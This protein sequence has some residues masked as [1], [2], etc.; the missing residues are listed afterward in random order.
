[1]REQYLQKLFEDKQIRNEINLGHLHSDED[2]VDNKKK[3]TLTETFVWQDTLKRKPKSDIFQQQDQMNHS[4]KQTG[5]AKKELQGPAA[6]PL[7]LDTVL[8]KEK[9]LLLFG[10]AG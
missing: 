9:Q 3:W 6:T 5:K 2:M 10:D 1:N 4:N 8:A 7:P